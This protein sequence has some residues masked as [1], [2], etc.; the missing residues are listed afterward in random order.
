MFDY[1]FTRLYVYTL[2]LTEADN[3]FNVVLVLVLLEIN[4]IPQRSA[5]FH[6]CESIY[7]NEEGGHTWPGC[8]SNAFLKEVSF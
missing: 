2:T 6:L 1:I 8:R 4:F 7:E 3:L 5:N